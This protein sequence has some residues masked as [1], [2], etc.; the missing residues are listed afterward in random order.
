VKQGRSHVR[1]AGRPSTQGPRALHELE[2]RVDVDPF[3]MSSLRGL[4]TDLA[5]KADF[6][7]DAVAD[8]TLAT[9][10]ACSELIGISNPEDTLACNFAIDAQRITI[11]ASVAADWWRTSAAIPTDTFGWRVM[12]TLVDDVEPLDE[13]RLIG[14]R[15]TKFRTWP[16]D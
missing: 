3:W 2:V 6:D 5:I 16:G 11:T 14:I 8:L 13:S 10:E 7:L 12:S 15:L 9:D 4:V 1:R